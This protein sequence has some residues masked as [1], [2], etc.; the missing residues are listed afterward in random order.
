M[1]GRFAFTDNEE[2]VIKDFQIEHSEVFLKPRY[3]I[4]P[5]QDIPVIIQQNEMRR[6]ETRRWGLIPFWSKIPKAMINARAESA[7]EKPA[8]KQA[9]RK[10]RCLIPASGFFEWAKKSKKKQPYFIC[11]KNKSPM[12]FAGLWEEWSAPDGKIIKTCAILTIEANSYLQSIH[13]RMP[14]ILDP[15]KGINWLDESG[16]E[17]S[18]KNLLLAFDSEFMEA[19]R[20]TSKVNVPSFDNP[21]CIERLDES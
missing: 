4:S 7:S 21:N 2:K 17:A 16:N 1:C 15:E 11:L 18:L 12:S 5:S 8:F 3:N 9:F 6:L 19:W 10:K 20:V 14:V 13:H